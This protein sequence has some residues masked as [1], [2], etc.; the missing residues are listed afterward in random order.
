MHMGEKNIGRKIAA[1]WELV[2]MVLKS[3]IMWFPDC[4]LSNK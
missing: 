4:I 1:L 2:V 3:M